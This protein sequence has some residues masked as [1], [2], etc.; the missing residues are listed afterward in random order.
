MQDQAATWIEVG[1][2]LATYWSN[3]GSMLVEYCKI[4]IL[5]LHLA[6]NL[7]QNMYKHDQDWTKLL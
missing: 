2:I 3:A 1:S 7:A 4:L 5:W 6:A